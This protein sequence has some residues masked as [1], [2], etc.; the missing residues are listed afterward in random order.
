M[1][2]LLMEVARSS[3]V[4]YNLLFSADAD[5]C[6]ARRIRRDTGEKGRD[7]GMVLDQLFSL[8]FGMKCTITRFILKRER[9]EEEAARMRKESGTE[10]IDEKEYFSRVLGDRRGWN[11]GVGRRLR[12]IAPDVSYVS[13]SQS[14]L[15]DIQETIRLMNENMRRMQEEI[16]ALILSWFGKHLVRLCNCLGVV[17]TL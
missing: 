8:V 1:S 6:L 5:M 11:M 3:I 13:N 17:D 7:I 14:Q 16:D 9:L 12:N 15:S 4:I 10:Q 2:Y